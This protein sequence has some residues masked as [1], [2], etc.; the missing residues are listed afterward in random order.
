M[1]NLEEVW[2]LLKIGPGFCGYLASELA[3]GKY[4]SQ[5][6]KINKSLLK[7]VN[8]QFVQHSVVR[9]G[10]DDSQAHQKILEI[11]A[12]ISMTALAGSKQEHLFNY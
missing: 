4:L 10:G 2:L 11:K 12:Q 7:I 8:F 3:P 5:S 6:N 1:G 9:I